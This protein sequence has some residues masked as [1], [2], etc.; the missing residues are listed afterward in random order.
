MDINDYKN[1]AKLINNLIDEINAI[2]NTVPTY[3]ATRH[4][5]NRDVYHNRFDF[6]KAQL[7]KYSS[8]VNK[9]SSA[10]SHNINKIV[11][12][13]RICDHYSEMFCRSLKTQPQ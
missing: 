13:K 10:M 12:A 7:Q 2:R 9:D 11:Q 5:Q 4:W 1:K 3:L 8:R 6:A